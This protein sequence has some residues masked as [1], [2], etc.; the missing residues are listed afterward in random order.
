M[1]LEILYLVRHGKA[2]SSHPKGDRHR[3]LSAE[4]RTRIADLVPKVQGLGWRVD[5]ALS[6]SYQRALQTRD[7]FVPF[8]PSVALGQSSAFSPL[9][10]AREALDELESWVARGSTRIAVFTHNPL[11][12]QLAEA[13]LAPGSVP[14]PVIGELVFHTPTV[15]ALA[16]PEGFGAHR[17]TPLWILH[18]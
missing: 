9:A 3:V 18:P 17:A 14:G 13:L 5:A 1:A 15:L 2:E 8:D 4:G 11:V 16:F 6:S 10:E 12:T 7:L